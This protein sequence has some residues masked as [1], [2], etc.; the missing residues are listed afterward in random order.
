MWYVRHA[1][2]CFAGMVDGMLTDR[3][4]SY[5]SDDMTRLFFIMNS[6]HIGEIP[7]LELTSGL[8]ILAVGPI[9]VAV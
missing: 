2:F 5:V 3:D 9:V 1:I 6:P 4:A 8:S 7:H